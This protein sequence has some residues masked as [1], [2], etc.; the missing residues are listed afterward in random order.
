MKRMVICL[1]FA[2]LTL[3]A[4][5]VRAQSAPTFAPV[6]CPMPIPA[7]AQV[8]CGETQ[9]PENRSQP[10][11]RMI[12]LPF[13]V[14]HSPNPNPQPDPVVFVSS[15]GPGGSSLDALAFYVNSAHLQERDFIFVEQRGNKYAK[16]VLECPEVQ[17]AAFANFSTVDARVA[18]I[19]REVDAA[20]ACRDRLLAQGIDLTAYNSAESAADLEDLRLLLGYEQW[21]LVGASY[22][23]RL[24]LTTMRL[25]PAGIRS[26]VLDSIYAPEV[27]AYE[28][29]V[30]TL[31]R[32]LETL[33]ANCA[34]D[35]ECGVAYPDLEEHLYA[36]IERMNAAPLAVNVRHPV[37]AEPVTLRLT[38]DD[39][40][41]GMFNALY[42]RNTIRFLPFIIEELYR[43]NAGVIEPL[44]QDG[45][46]NIFSRAQGMY[47]SVECREEYPFNDPAT[48][49]EIASQYPALA[50]F[51]PSISEP[52]ICAMWDAGV[53]D[54]S[55]NQAVMS[56]VPALVLA[57]EYD[58]V[59]SPAFT[60]AAAQNLSASRFYLLP[61]F[62]HA[63]QDQSNCANQLA[64]SFIQSPTSEPD[65]ACLQNLS[66]LD[67]VTV[68]NDVIPTRLVYWA[69]REILQDSNTLLAAVLA[70]V[71]LGATVQVGMFALKFKS[72]RSW[73]AILPSITALLT[74]A[75]LFWFYRVIATA[76]VTLLGFGLPASAR[77]LV[78]LCVVTAA[79]AL[80]S[81]AAQFTKRKGWNM[82]EK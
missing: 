60:Q 40:I 23:A 35:A 34:A 4:L 67:F 52:A 26:V 70:L 13:A 39:L 11:G 8:T 36:V 42:Q 24:V 43:G 33:F 32:A 78:G 62:G 64:A 66:K 55:E 72:M 73:A 71:M 68:G 1:V 10:N 80:A 2:A 82:K 50:N 74:L 12:R 47:Y 76:D 20:R 44:A 25:Y 6:E 49:Q 22:A 14:L 41:L 7:G 45:F 61:Y 9:V 59:T 58:P 53:A 19:A 79:F 46:K 48:Q 63:V 31:A 81:I 56:D 15:G 21:N 27:D 30:P 16:P 65:A 38:G 17:M 37:T 69:N 18:E 29:R 77:G 28:Q 51:L 5:P 54:A 3:G 57:G 75:A